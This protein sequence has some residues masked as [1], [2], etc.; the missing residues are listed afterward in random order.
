MTYD[1]MAMACRATF[2]R[3]WLIGVESEKNAIASALVTA[4]LL[5]PHRK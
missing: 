4:V 3:P 1:D 5:L 2:P